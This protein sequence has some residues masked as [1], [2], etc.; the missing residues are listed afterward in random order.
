MAEYDYAIT[1]FPNNR[2]DQKKFM[3]ES[4]ASSLNEAPLTIA[5]S[6]DG[7]TVT[8]DYATTVATATLDALVA[9]HD[10]PTDLEVEKDNKM[11]AIDA[12]T[13]LL[14]GNGFV[15]D[16]VTFSLS[17]PAQM[18]LAQLYA[19]RADVLF[20]YP[21][22]FNNIDNTV[23]YSI[24]NAVDLADMYNTAIETVRGHVDAGTLLK[25]QVRAAT[26]IGQV[27]AVADT[28]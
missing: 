16:S 8:F 10:S 23:K 19:L 13:R 4:L 9:A 11:W 18:K 20:D 1:A 15:Y 28:R 26:T 12:K 3:E 21:V 14:L 17:P 27:D 5:Q 6:D 25:D 2:V 24:S 7:A 22:L